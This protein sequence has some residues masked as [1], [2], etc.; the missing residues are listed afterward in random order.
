MAK[1]A[2]IARIISEYSDKGTKAAAKDAE[3][4]GKQFHDFG[5][6][7]AKSFAIAAAASAAFAIKMG[8]D[9]VRAAM[10]EEQSMAILAK[11]L[12]NVTGAT[13][14]QIASVNTYIKQTMLRL[15]VQDELLR[16]SLQALLIAT[17]DIT[18]AES[19]QQIALDV[20]ANRGKDLTA[21]SIALAKAYAGNFNALKRLGIPLSETLIKSKD[22]VGIVK[23]LESA[24]K[25]SAAAAADTFAGKIGRIGLAFDEV[26]KTIGNAIILALQ[27]FLDK[28]T[29][30]LPQIEKWL[31]ANGK[32][33]A[34]FFITGISYG[35][36]FAQVLYDTFSFVARNIKTFEVLG[37][38]IVAA[39]FGA[40]VAAAVQGMITAVMA[41]IK[42][43][44]ALRTVSLGAAAAEA[45]ATGGISAAAGAAAFGVALIAINVATN[46]FDKDAEKAAAK[47]GDLKFNFKGLALTTADY[48]KGLGKTSGATTKL[49]ADQIKAA[50]VAAEL[51]ALQKQLANKGVTATT[52]TD[53]IQLEAVRLN[54]LKQH[55]VELDMAY[56]RLMA[57]YEAQMSNNTAAQRYADILGTLADK[58]I[59]VN[60]VNM[61]AKKWGESQEAVVAYI[62][63]VLGADTYSKALTNP[64][65]VA[66]M[67][68][69]N[70]LS[71]LDVYISTLKAIPAYNPNVTSGAAFVATQVA[72]IDA[73]TKAAEAAIAVA[74]AAIAAAEKAINDPELNKILD[75]LKNIPAKTYNTG[76]NN[77]GGLSGAGQAGGG[78][79]FGAVTGTSTSMFAAT[80]A[81]ATDSSASIGGG[82]YITVNNAGSV[83]SNTD[84]VASITQGVQQNQLSGKA[85]TFNGQY[86]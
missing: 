71:Q 43:M 4:L 57:N 40:K 9:S 77:Y 52:E 79:G 45:L 67:G 60:E 24:T 82:L 5:N 14:S 48:L 75:A 83:I 18:K 51:L 54:L 38:V 20:S 10:A 68:W 36:A 62:A 66:A 80:S 81:P 74:D 53:P 29:K 8:V 69:R 6:K 7:V 15:N 16:P 49:T 25:G 2:V 30:Y 19:L 1:G 73:A 17:H 64:G 59:S 22:F 33:I 41:I 26:R 28:F 61:L 85:L 42:V 34:A 72:D 39:L 31:D 23:E 84:L 47:V 44:K 58:D 70:A 21:V 3:K 12:Q 86:F 76:A 13:D 35:V 27:P 50:K 63:S 37:A 46:K 55:N 11:T 32:K 65:D 78:G 56:A